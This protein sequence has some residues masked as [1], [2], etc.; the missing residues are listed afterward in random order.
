MASGYLIVE[1]VQVHDPILQGEEP[2][3]VA[4]GELIANTV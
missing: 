4:L 1:L 2:W 3:I